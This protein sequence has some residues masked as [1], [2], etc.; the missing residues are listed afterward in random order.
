MPNDATLHEFR[1]QQQLRSSV[2]TM[3]PRCSIAYFLLAR[4]G[5]GRPS[6]SMPTPRS[7]PSSFAPRFSP[8]RTRARPHAHFVLAYQYLT[9]EHREAGGSRTEDGNGLSARGRRSL[10]TVRGAAVP[11]STGCWE[12][13]PRHN[14]R[15]SPCLRSPPCSPPERKA[16]SRQSCQP[17]KGHHD[18]RCH[19]SVMA[20]RLE[21]EPRARTRSLRAKLSFENGILTS[22]HRTRTTIRWW[23]T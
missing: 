15:K 3:P 5:I 1:T 2:T 9:E 16:S 8:L 7:I 12:R 22:L 14:P 20:F 13:R 10:V 4:D 23:A 19:C 6:A 21:R 18:Q 17:S 11:E